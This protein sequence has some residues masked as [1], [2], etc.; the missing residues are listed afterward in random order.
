M[1]VIDQQHS[2]WSNKSLELLQRE[3]ESL[4]NHQYL[5]RT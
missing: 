2:T 4:D 5:Q 1:M 3:I